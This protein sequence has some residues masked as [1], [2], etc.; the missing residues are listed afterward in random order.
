MQMAKALIVKDG[1]I[2][3][4]A[5][6]LDKDSL[7]TWFND[8]QFSNIESINRWKEYQPL[9]LSSDEEVELLVE[10]DSYSIFNL[11]SII[12]VES[13]SNQ[14][15]FYIEKM[16]FFSTLTPLSVIEEVLRDK[17][18][19]RVH[20]N[21]LVNIFHFRRFVRCDA[22]ITLSNSDA[23]PV[24]MGND[25]SIVDFFSKHSII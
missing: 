13:I 25:K 8:V 23:I 14:C 24:G 5:R 7:I 10:G 18:F 1:F 11:N 19:I 2:H 12:R 16:G 15:F 17:D 21:H 4:S 9:Y 6:S 3:E 20:P 22:F